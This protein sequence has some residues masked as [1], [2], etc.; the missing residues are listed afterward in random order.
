MRAVDGRRDPDGAKLRQV[1]ARRWSAGASWTAAARGKSA[2]LAQVIPH[3]KLVTYPDAAHG[4]FFQESA[5]FLP[6]L[7]AFLR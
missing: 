4:F 2:P 5:D 1:R 3:A 6:R 7:T